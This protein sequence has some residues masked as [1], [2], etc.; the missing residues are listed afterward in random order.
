MAR[1]FHRAAA[2]VGVLGLGV[3]GCGGGTA[4][5][6]ADPATTAATATQPTTVTTVP[7]TSPTLDVSGTYWFA[8]EDAPNTMTGT[9]TFEQ[10]GDLVRVTGTKYENTTGLRELKGEATIHGTRL[11]MVLVPIND[12]PTYVAHVL[13]IFSEDGS[14]FGVSFSDTNGDKGGMG[15]YIG[16]RQ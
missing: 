12:D 14:V 6:T 9:I 1:T 3:S 10:E 2:L 4:A 8:G 13:F 5:T 11:E 16:V 7:G 15:S